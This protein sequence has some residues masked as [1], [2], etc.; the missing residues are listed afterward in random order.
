MHRRSQHAAA[1][2][3]SSAAVV[4]YDLYLAVKDEAQARHYTL[5]ESPLDVQRLVGELGQP[6]S[7]EKLTL[8]ANGP[9]IIKPGAVGSK[10][11]GQ[12]V[13]GENTNTRIE[14]IDTGEFEIISDQDDAKVFRFAGKN[15]IGR[16]LLTRDGQTKK[17]NI[18]IEVAKED[19]KDDGNGNGNDDGDGDGNSDKDDEKNKEDT[20]LDPEPLSVDDFVTPE[21]DEVL[22][23]IINQTNMA[24]DVRERMTAIRQRLSDKTVTDRDVVY[25]LKYISGGET[26]AKDSLDKQEPIALAMW[27]QS[28]DKKIVY[29]DQETGDEYNV[30]RDSDGTYSIPRFQFITEGEY[31][32][33]KFDAKR[34]DE[35][36]NNFSLLT[37]TK[38]LDVP[39]KVGHHKNQ[40]LLGNKGELA[41]GWV[42]EIWGENSKDGRKGFLKITGMPHTLAYLVAKKALK[43]RSAEIFANVNYKGK[44]YGP[45]LKAISFLGASTPAVLGMQGA[46]SALDTSVKMYSENG[47]K[48]IIVT[49][50]RSAT[51]GEPN[52]ITLSADELNAK[53]N[54]AVEAAVKQIKVATDADANA[55]KAQVTELSMKLKDEQTA[56]RKETVKASSAANALEFDSLV[57][58]GHVLPVQKDEFLQFCAAIDG[59]TDMAKGRD[60]SDMFGLVKANKDTLEFSI[61]TIEADKKVQ[62]NIGMKP[63][64]FR[65][66]KSQ[67]QIDLSVQS[68]DGTKDAKKIEEKSKAST[69]DALIELT[70]K[71]RDT[72]KIPYADALSKAYAQSFGDESA[73]AAIEG[74]TSVPAKS[75][76]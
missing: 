20:N 41:H 74:R 28:S 70:Q 47:S 54:A 45:A 6:V 69:A 4:V 22:T 29:L 5:A 57:K 9:E 34:I 71:I 61:D 44:D 38:I 40:S 33:E 52:Q 66:L 17:F 76:E 73:E 13:S 43:N 53:I 37:K 16:M 24:D 75:A 11:Q 7:K 67:K 1:A 50:N 2:A 32:G 35:V 42:P 19:K 14:M 8:A 25:V 15:L 10:E 51:V 46:S 3:D 72:E 59:V 23:S 58:G 55:M 30:V 36:I 56:R 21:F 39:V 18:S 31:N 27:G 26:A 62:V 68:K 65:L 12:S 48:V 63:L 49:P 60:L 64:F